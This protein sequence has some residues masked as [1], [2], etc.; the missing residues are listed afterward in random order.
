MSDNVQKVV[1][2]K[3]GISFFGILFIVLLLLKVGVVETAVIGWSWWWITA[4]LWGP[5][6]LTIGILI[7]IVVVIALV[8][9]VGLIITGI[10]SLCEI[11]LR[12]FAYRAGKKKSNG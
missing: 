8:F 3:Q 4:P 11:G 5:A 2:T 12:S 10:A 1:V 6:A 7:M 9:V